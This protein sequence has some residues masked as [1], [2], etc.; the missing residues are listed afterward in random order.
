[1]W[2]GSLTEPFSLEHFDI[3]I[4][5]FWMLGPQSRSDQVVKVGQETS[6]PFSERTS[7]MRL[8]SITALVKVGKNLHQCWIPSRRLERFSI[9]F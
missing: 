7:V 9:Q 8:K 5:H 2:D 1:M 6:S 3:C 4:G